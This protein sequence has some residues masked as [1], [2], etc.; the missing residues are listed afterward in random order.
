MTNKLFF[1]IPIYNE[2]NNIEK[3]IKS[4]NKDSLSL[5][6]KIKTFLCLNGCLDNSEKKH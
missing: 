6:K 2:E 5:N 3:C 1:A 4:L